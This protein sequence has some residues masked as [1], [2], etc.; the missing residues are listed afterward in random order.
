[1]AMYVYKII[2]T[3]NRKAY[4]GI[5][6]DI[7]SRFSFHRTRYNK[8]TKPE[9]VEKPLYRAFRKY[10][11]ENFKFLVLYEG[12]SLS[13]AKKKEVELIK[14]FKTLAHENGY[15]ITKGGDWR[16]NSGENNNTTKLT[17]EEVLDIRKQIEN[18]ENIKIVY[19][20]Y[21]DK[22]T[23]AGFQGIYLGRNWKYLGQPKN[24]V[25]PN[26]ASV[27]KDTVL[28]IRAMFNEGKNPHQIAN[29]LGLEYKKCWRI[30]KG[31]TYK[32]V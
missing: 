18:G 25:L 5:T 23:F 3:F 4:I 13:E 30:C 6:K 32:N 9:Y 17:E 15:N 31:D 12:L 22:I 11:L 26:G 7:E 20:K 8:D 24:N 19:K 28:K 21:S 27:N 2:N 14:K 1:M 10:G 29:E 16:A